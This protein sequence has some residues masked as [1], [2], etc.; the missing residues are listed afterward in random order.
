[1]C[2]EIELLAGNFLVGLAN[3]YVKTNY[4]ND[5]KDIKFD[6]VSDDYPLLNPHGISRASHDISTLNIFSLGISTFDRLCWPLRK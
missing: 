4:I 1:M 3:N 2:T 6:L 5:T